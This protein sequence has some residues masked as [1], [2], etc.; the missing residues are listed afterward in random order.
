MAT[1]LVGRDP[2]AHYENGETVCCVLTVFFLLGPRAGVV[3]WWILDPV[4]WQLAFSSWLWS[5]IG[6]FVAPWTTMMWV[7][8][9]PGGVAG[10]DWLWIGLAVLLDISFWTG[11]AWGNRD[12]MP[13]SSQAA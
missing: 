1:G 5:V 2:A 10:L 6:F 3:I 8:V 9:A 7:L 11:G 4:R 12:R 13:G